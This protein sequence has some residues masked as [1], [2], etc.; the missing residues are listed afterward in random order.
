MIVE[1]IIF[2]IILWIFSAVGNP[3]YTEVKE[4][5]IINHIEQILD[6]LCKDAGVSPDFSV[7]EHDGETSYVD[8]PNPTIHLVIRRKDGSL[9]DQKTLIFVAI[10]ELAHILCPGD[11]HPPLFDAIENYL[12]SLAQKRGLI[13]IS[14]DKIDSEYPCIDD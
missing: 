7:T 1:I 13:S 9:F 3:Q 4:E 2:L 5:P 11:G 12:L 6:Q 14:S 8:F 10:H